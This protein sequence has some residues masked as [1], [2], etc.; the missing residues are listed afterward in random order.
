MHRL[1]LMHCRI[2]CHFLMDIL[3]VSFQIIT[4]RKGLATDWTLR[5]L[6]RSLSDWEIDLFVK[7]SAIYIFPPPPVLLI[8]TLTHILIHFSS[9]FSFFPPPP[10][11]PPPYFSFSSFSSFSSI[12]PPSPQ[13]RTLQ[14]KVDHN[15]SV[16]V[17]FNGIFKFYIHNNV[18]SFCQFTF[19]VHPK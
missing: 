8:L 16:L 5:H 15:R 6:F 14:G 11:P 10:L 7:F 2:R 12:P 4:L 19:E 18:D 1:L 17:N 13:F 9:S 3:Y